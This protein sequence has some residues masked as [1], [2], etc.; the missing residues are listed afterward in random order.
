MEELKKMALHIKIKLYV[1]LC[2][3]IFNKVYR[4]LTYFMESGLGIN[5]DL[6]I[7]REYS[8]LVKFKVLN[9]G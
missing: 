9:Y 4:S 2:I 3:E 6:K 1:L 7:C 5:T 8:V